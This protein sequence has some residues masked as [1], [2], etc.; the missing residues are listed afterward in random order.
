MYPHHEASKVLD[1]LQDVYYPK[2][3]ARLPHLHLESGIRATS[4]DPLL[5]DPGFPYNFQ[6]GSKLYRSCSIRNL[7]IKSI[8]RCDLGEGLLFQKK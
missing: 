4:M 8:L 7:F 3:V 5:K 1:F 6:K 2:L